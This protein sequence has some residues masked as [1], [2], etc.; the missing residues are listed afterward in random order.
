MK[1]IKN[2]FS[3]KS[4][5]IISASQFVLLLSLINTVLFNGAL[6]SFLASN[7]NLYSIS[8]IIIAASV[9]TVVFIVNLLFISILSIIAPITVKP[10]FIVTAFINSAALY[11]LV[12]YQVIIDKTMMGNIFNT[13]TSESFDLLTPTLLIYIFIFSIIPSIL[14]LK[15]KVKPLNRLK[16]I[17]NFFLIFII[18]IFFLYL[19]SSSWLWI[20]KHAKLLGGKLLP[21]SYIINT[22]R[23]YSDVSRS[24][25]NKILLPV[26]TFSDN[27]KTAVVLI[28]GETARSHNFSL[29]GYPRNTNP[30]LQSEDILVFNK[31]T[32]CTTYT[33]GSVACMLS[34]NID[35]SNYEP[36]PSYLTRLG[37][38]VI[39]RTNNW[40]EP[41]IHVSKYQKGSELRKQCHGEGCEFDEV[42]LSKIDNEIEFSEKQKIFMVLHTKGSHGPSYYSRYPSEF[43]KFS[44]V[45]RYEEISKCTPQELINA[46]DNTILYT[47]YFLHKAIQKLK[48]LKIPVMLIYASDH[49]ESLGEKGLYLHGTPFMFAPKYQ[50]EI[51]FIIW[52]SEELIKLQ[53]LDNKNVSQTGAFSHANIFHTIIG[54]FGI[55]TDVYNKDLDVLLN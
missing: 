33:T 16:I 29:Y 1:A 30:Q 36:L 46:Y 39:W 5:W 28:I 55:K 14:L 12:S 27:N 23:Y 37:A 9:L 7:L 49:G 17:F 4:S 25:K 8:G 40:G 35:K 38:N 22:A 26:G 20:D 15:V 21:W 10:L 52:R 18:S 51:P 11:Y 41:P 24:S 19:N 42:L 3:Q 31:T 32:S 34:H 2:I 50:K 44:P 6:Y 13:R 53:G 47:D 45:C 54:V 48:K 43:E